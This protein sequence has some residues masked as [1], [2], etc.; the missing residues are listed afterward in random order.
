MQKQ[1]KVFEIINQDSA[2]PLILTCEHASNAIPAGY[3]NLGLPAAALDTH[4]ARDKGC[5]ELT[6]A[7]AQ[8]LGCT[9]FLAGYS[10]L[11]ID[12]NRRENETDLILAE[13]DKVQIPGN[14]N[15]SAAER[16]HRIENYHRPY[17][18]AIMAKIDSLRRQ[19]ITPRIFSVHA[20]TPQL[21]GGA[22]RPWHAGILYVKPNIFAD[23]LLQGLQ[24]INGLAADANVPYDMRRY[25]TGAAAICGEDIGLENAVIEIRDSEFD[26]MSAGIEKWS[27]LLC[28]VLN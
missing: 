5:K 19:G 3:E 22:F 20:F 16:R 6:A 23:K 26:D 17:Y 13:S 18:R 8:K 24:Q 1:D 2:N 4:I 11:F 12:Y 14:Q 28:N 27:N 7:L 9:A 10:R 21:R 25:N 15:L